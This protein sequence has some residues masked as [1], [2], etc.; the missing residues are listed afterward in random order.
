MTSLET[1]WYKKFSWSLLLLPLSWIFSVITGLRRFGFAQGWLKQTRFDVPV[2]VV[3][4]INVGGTGKTPFVVWLVE[5]LKGQGFAPGVVARGYGASHSKNSPDSRLLTPTCVASEVGDEPLLVFQRCDCPVAIGRSRVR[6][7]EL[8][9]AQGCDIIVSDDGLQH[10]SLAR[11]IE[12]VIVDG[13]RGFGNKQLLPAGPLRESVKRLQQADIV[14]VN[15]GTQSSEHACQSRQLHTYIDSVTAE[16][17]VILGHY[18]VETQALRSVQTQAVANVTS[19][20]DVGLVCGIGNPER[21]EQAIARHGIQSESLTVFTDHHA[22][23]AQ[24]F[25]PFEH[26]TIIMT[27]KDA[28][29]CRDFAEA[30]WYYLPI[31]AEV[32]ANVSEAITTLLRQFTVTHEDN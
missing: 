22:F 14:V 20:S 32:S 8:L 25:Q 26:Q 31:T 9:M 16:S 27:E 18:C 30:H 5:Y 29:K 6:S 19:L 2:I 12:V 15:Q 21:F 1:A 10:Y 4:N 3:G 13:V 17:H 23:T 11:D 24:D 7:A 28:V